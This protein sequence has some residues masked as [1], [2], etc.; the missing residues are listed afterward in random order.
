MARQSRRNSGGPLRRR[1]PTRDR[2]PLILVVCEGQITEPQYIHGFSVARGV[3]TVRLDVRAPGGDPLA[4]VK[5]A[6][7]VRD[8][9]RAEAR[10]ADDEDLAY[11][12]SWCVVDVDQHPQLDE[13]RALAAKSGLELAISNPC[14][15]LWLLLHFADQSAHLPV[16]DAARKLTRYLPGYDKHLRFADLDG[17]YADAVRRAVA[18]ERR[19][20]EMDSASGNPSTGVYRLMQRIDA[21]SRSARLDR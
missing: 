15:E 10:R 6:I 19:H 9:A 20:Q 3:T 11:D 16:A 2:L 7:K 1:G 5:R 12:Q 4:L 13:A 18:L 14:F 17:G 21:N 8:T